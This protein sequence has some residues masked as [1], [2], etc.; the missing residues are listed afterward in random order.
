[1]VDAACRDM[2]DSNDDLLETVRDDLMKTI[3]SDHQRALGT[4]DR[5]A[6]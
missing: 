2:A 4:L 1:M 6:G 5:L 3:I